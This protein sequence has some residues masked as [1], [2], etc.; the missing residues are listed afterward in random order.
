LN[1]INIIFRYFFKSLVERNLI[2]KIE[3][4]ELKSIHE[5]NLINEQSAS[6]SSLISE[7]QSKRSYVSIENESGFSSND[8]SNLSPIKQI[9]KNIVD[10]ITN[11]IIENELESEENNNNGFEFLKTS[12]PAK[13][14]VNNEINE[15]L[16]LISK[17]NNITIENS[18]ES[19]TEEDLSPEIDPNPVPECFY[20]SDE[21]ESL[22]KK[23][24]KKSMNQN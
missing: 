3:H 21:N 20:S 18:V 2:S 6:S 16:L 8:S 17:E 11:E 12:T 10:V 15:E 7:T 19:N 5:Q 9:I 13:K 22:N 23:K 24:F 4:N 1:Y 14:F